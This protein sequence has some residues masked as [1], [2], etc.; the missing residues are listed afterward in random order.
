MNELLRLRL[1]ANA[2]VV[3]TAELAAAG[4]DRYAT[5][6]LVKSGELVRVR[7]GSFVG[8][9]PSAPATPRRAMC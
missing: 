7:A 8:G 2:G 9:E 5:R 3:Q 6:A 1:L 4:Y